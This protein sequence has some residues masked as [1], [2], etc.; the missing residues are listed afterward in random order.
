MLP[1][2]AQ[3]RRVPRLVFGLIVFGFGLALVILGDFGLPGWD[4]FHQGLANRT[5]LSIGAAVMVVGAVLL[6]AMAALRER[7][8]LGT[9][10]NVL[11]IGLAID[12]TLW[13]VDEPSSTIA[14]VV[15]TFV[16]PLV[17]AV[18]SG[19]YLGTRLGSGPRDG[20]MTALGS[21]GV[22][23]W[24]ARFGIEAMAL[25][26]GVIL[27]GT[28]GWGTI[29]FMVIIGP[30]VQ[31]ALPRLSLPLAPDEALSAAK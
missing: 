27:G 24:K 21:R 29:W 26:G 12:A 31:F 6:L 25:I 9:V 23:L 7:I 8:G 4:V 30:A 3:L 18:G 17:V 14:R 19:V 11:V 22:A 1:V 2:S 16:G 28:V 13:L 5:P 10:A 20:I 15:L